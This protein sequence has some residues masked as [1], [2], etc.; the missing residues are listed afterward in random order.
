VLAALFMKRGL[1]GAGTDLWHKIQRKWGSK[2]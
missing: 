1:V 2:S